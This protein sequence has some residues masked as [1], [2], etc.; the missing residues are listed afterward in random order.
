MPHPRLLLA[1]LAVALPAAA[2]AGCGDD[3]AV[4]GPPPLTTTGTTATTTT[5]PRPRRPRVVTPAG[6][7]RLRGEVVRGRGFRFRVDPGVVD[8]TKRFRRVIAPPQKLLVGLAQ[9]TGDVGQIGISIRPFGDLVD[10][11]DRL[12]MRTEAV[13]GL[14]GLGG[15]SVRGLPDARLGGQRAY[16]AESLGRFESQKVLVIRYLVARGDRLLTID[17]LVPSRS[18]S[19]AEALLR[20]IVRSWRW[21]GRG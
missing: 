7:A 4:T 16:R 6:P 3:G 11:G 20:T 19:A 8:S 13:E 2:L 15:K 1:A 9:Q 12:S 10:V 17:G 18:R 14:R 21:T 5:T